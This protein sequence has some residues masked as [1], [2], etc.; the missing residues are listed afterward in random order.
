MVIYQSSQIYAVEQSCLPVQCL[1]KLK[2]KHSS[3]TENKNQYVI[4]EHGIG[5]FI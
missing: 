3:R 1:P 4:V 2:M 5:S